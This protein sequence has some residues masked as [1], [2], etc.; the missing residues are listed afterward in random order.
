MDPIEIVQVRVT[1]LDNAVKV[2]M[3]RSSPE[4]DEGEL[5]KLADKLYD[6]V[7]MGEAK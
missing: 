4:I 3:R 6:W 2:L 7:R 1:C 5:I